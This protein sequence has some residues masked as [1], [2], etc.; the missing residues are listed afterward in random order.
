M[1]SYRFNVN[2]VPAS[3]PRVSRYGTYHLPTYRAF[4]AAMQEEIATNRDAYNKW[5]SDQC[6]LVTVACYVEKPKSSKRDRPRGDVDN[7]AKAVL[8][9]LNGVL[10]EDDDQITILIAHKH[11]SEDPRIEVEVIPVTDDGQDAMPQMRGKRGRR[12][13]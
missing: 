1:D 6:L 11:Y 4:K 12:K 8:D 3:R 10:W 5:P 2:P 9:S 13:G 7:Y